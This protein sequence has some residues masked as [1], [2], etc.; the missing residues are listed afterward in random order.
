MFFP[1][2]FCF[3]FRDSY[4]PYVG[5][6]PP[7]FNVHFLLNPISFFFLIFLH[8]IIYFLS[9]YLLHL[10]ALSNLVFIFEMI[11]FLILSWVLSFYFLSCII[12]L[13][14]LFWNIVLVFNCYADMPLWWAFIIYRDIILHFILFSYNFVWDFTS[15]FFYFIFLYEIS[16]PKLL[17]VV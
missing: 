9:Y 11:L 6:F 3:K 17:D 10:I 15:T 12:F 2:L 7:I 13:N 8:L 5:S 4:Y 16:F 14:T 1:S